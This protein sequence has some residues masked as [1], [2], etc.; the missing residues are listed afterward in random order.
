MDTRDFKGKKLI[1]NGKQV[2]SKYPFRW[3]QMGGAT[4]GRSQWSHF[5]HYYTDFPY[6]IPVDY[7]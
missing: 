1:I 3:A 4:M 7:R 5:G 2:I 6:V